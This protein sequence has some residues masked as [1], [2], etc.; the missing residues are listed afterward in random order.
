[1][2]NFIITI[3]INHPQHTLLG[4][5]CDL[6]YFQYNVISEL[7]KTLTR[8]TFLHPEHFQIS[9]KSDDPEPNKG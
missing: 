5:E 2:K 7:R 6:Q 3:T 9:V 8:K 4:D 1:M